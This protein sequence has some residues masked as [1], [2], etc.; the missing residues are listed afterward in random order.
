VPPIH[1]I[2]ATIA[3]GSVA[4]LGI[5][6]VPAA[7]G[8]PVSRTLIDALLVIVLTATVIGAATGGVL[9]AIGPGPADVLHALY[10]GVAVVALPFARVI[11]ARRDPPV[12]LSASRGLG[13]WLVAG[14][15]VTLGVLLRL[16]MT[17]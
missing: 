1:A 12:G 2:L 8:R 3:A 17:G 15:L 14:A 7:A 16:W 13:R 10:A 6:A 9:L 5:A 11:G 4:A